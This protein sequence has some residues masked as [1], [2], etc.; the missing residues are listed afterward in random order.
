MLARYI[1]HNYLMG[2]DL[3][4]ELLEEVDHELL[5]SM[6]HMV[7]LFQTRQLRIEMQEFIHSLANAI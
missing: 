5:N 2:V 6:N 3:D 1:L 4:S 7:V